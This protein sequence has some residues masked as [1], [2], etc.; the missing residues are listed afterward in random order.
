[1]TIA[2][3]HL[4]LGDPQAALSA[5]DRGLAA[6]GWPAASATSLRSLW[7]NLLENDRFPEVLDPEQLSERA[8]L[9][10]GAGRP[11]EAR[12][13]M[14]RACRERSGWSLPY[15]DVDPRFAPFRETPGLESLARCLVG[16]Y[17]LGPWSS[18]P[19]PTR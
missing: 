2:F 3:S 11:E 4:A 10:L 16:E 9:V 13:L 17:D 15:Y 19:P 7:R 12:Q 1:M 8:F 14:T 5:A 6:R 18:T